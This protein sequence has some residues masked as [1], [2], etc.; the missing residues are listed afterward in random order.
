MR[1]K[2]NKNGVES[3]YAS[4]AAAKKIELGRA[5][6]FNFGA[7]ANH[8]GDLPITYWPWDW[9]IEMKV[10]RWEQ[11]H[12][13]ISSEIG[14]PFWDKTDKPLHHKIE[15][16]FNS[17]MVKV[18]R[19]YAKEL[20]KFYK[21][22]MVKNKEVEGFHDIYELYFEGGSIEIDTDENLFLNINI[23]S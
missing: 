19:S 16:P 5:M 2:N 23:G 8:K 21:S 3:A 17:D 7:L 20:Q 11:E 12:K 14:Y 4:T 22:E 9:D 10:C 6:S 15:I 13:V 1:N 18:L